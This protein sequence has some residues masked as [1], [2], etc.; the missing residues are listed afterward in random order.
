LMDTE[1]KKK[2]VIVVDDH[3]KVLR[4]IEINLRI[5]FRVT[6]PLATKMS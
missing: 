2:R 3:P 5:R 4:F 6:F 1:G